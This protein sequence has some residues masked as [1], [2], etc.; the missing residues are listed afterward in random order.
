MTLVYVYSLSSVIP[1][2]MCCAVLARA[3]QVCL[4]DVRKSW[5]WRSSG[6]VGLCWGSEKG[7]LLKSLAFW[8]CKS[9]F[10]TTHA[11]SRL[12]ISPIQ[13]KTADMQ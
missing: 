2:L 5:Y 11:T 7:H 9:A 4:P 3:E 8:T 1:T 12:S 13:N 10:S 6:G